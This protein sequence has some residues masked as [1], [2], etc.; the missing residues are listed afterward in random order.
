VYTRDQTL[1]YKYQRTMNSSLHNPSLFHRYSVDFPIHTHEDGQ[2]IYQPPLKRR[3]H[4]GHPAFGCWDRTWLIRRHSPEDPPFMHGFLDRDPETSK[5]RSLYFKIIGGSLFL[6]FTYVIWGVLPIYWA[7]VF[8]LYDHAHNLHGWVVVSISI[9]TTPFV[10]NLNLWFP[11]GSRWWGHRPDGVTNIYRWLR[12]SHKDDLGGGSFELKPNHSRTVR[13][14]GGGRESVGDHC[15]YVV[16]PRS[17][18]DL[19]HAVLS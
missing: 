9:S 3:G 10:F 4:R 2:Q 7:S 5:A 12:S 13:K 11:S 14:C 18:L 1:W 19:T 17:P 16:F 8:K 6:V 15:Q